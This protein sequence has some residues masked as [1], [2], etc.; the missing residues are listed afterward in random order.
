MEE[1]LSQQK[2]KPQISI[3]GFGRFGRLWASITKA[4]F[5]VKVYDPSKVALEQASSLGVEASSLEDA[6]AAEVIFYCVPISQFARTI[7]DHAAHFKNTRTSK[8]LIDL[9]SVKVHAKEIFAKEL[10]DNC[11]AMLCHP[12]FGPDSVNEFGLAGQR[13]VIEQFRARDETFKFWRNYFNNL[14]LETIEI[15]AEEHDQQMAYSQALTHLVGRILSNMHLSGTIPGY[16]VDTTNCKK[17]MEVSEQ[18]SKDEFQLFL[19]MQRY[20]PYTRAMREK[21]SQAKDDLYRQIDTLT[22]Q[23]D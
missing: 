5:Q 14:K 2:P 8:V 7:A 15:T 9:L 4:D 23:A 22:M 20:N 19:D 1:E 6:L 17:L 10:P 3:I 11:E 18:V 21:F 16:Q 13:I 12:L